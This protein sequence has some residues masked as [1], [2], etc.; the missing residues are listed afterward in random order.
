MK[1]KELK[2]GGNVI[3][4][5]KKTFN[6]QKGVLY[7]VYIDR[8]FELSGMRPTSIIVSIYNQ[9]KEKK[10]KKDSHENITNTV[11]IVFLCVIILIA[12]ITTLKKKC[13][14]K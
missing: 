1:V 6:S 14:N 10:E 11:I 5:L 12:V 8:N 4:N 2:E 13:K 3:I 9:S 7:G